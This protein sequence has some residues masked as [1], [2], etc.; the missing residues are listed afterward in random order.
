LKPQYAA[1]LL[2]KSSTPAHSP[3]LRG[4]RE[5]KAFA[6]S[7]E[8]TAAEEKIKVHVQS[9]RDKG[10]SINVI[11]TKSIMRAILET[12]CPAM[13]ETCK[14]S[15]SF[16]HRWLHQQMNYSWRAKTT[17][18]SRVPDNWKELGVLMAKRIAVNVH[19]YLIHPSLVINMD[20]TGV[21]LVPSSNRT[22]APIGSSSIAVLGADDKRQI[23]CCIASSMNGDLLPLQLVF[24]GKTTK[25]EPAATAA[26]IA[27]SVHITHSDNHWSTQETMQQYIKE[28]IVPY[29]KSKIQE[30]RLQAD[31]RVVLVLDVW[32][33]H[34]S[35][36]FRMFLRQQHPNIHLV[37]VP[38]CCTSKL[39]VAD[40][41]LQR[42]FKHGI[43]SRFNEWV[44][45]MIRDQIAANNLIGLNAYL[46]MSSIKPKV[47][48]W[49]IES[50]TRLKDQSVYI[51][52][53]WKLCVFD[54][55]DITK[56][57]NIMQAV[58][59]AADNQLDHRLVPEGQDE[60][61]EEDDSEHE[62]DEE[63]DELDVLQKR[64]Y[65]ERNSNRKRKQSVPFGYQVN[66]SQ[67]DFAASSSEDSDADG[68][69]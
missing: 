60:D 24:Q 47:L 40:V 45:E 61:D 59:E 21:H 68:M 49:C 48:Q 64:V 11:V 5:T 7:A 23:T 51:R 29:T 15:N 2:L 12:D 9:L 46:K 6:A 31:T 43:R 17:A 36:E 55:F 63:K 67:L 25:C 8:A 30:H 54:L 69:A 39:Q 37:F 38:A 20:Q 3:G 28:V 41:I 22:F 19:M 57:E 35:E 16:V 18:A 13:L 32:A 4:H 56:Q 66:S 50:W 58:Q 65:G 27:A 34:K 52:A 53:G 26:S 14:L 44:A 42:P 62:S 10:A 1:R 33:V